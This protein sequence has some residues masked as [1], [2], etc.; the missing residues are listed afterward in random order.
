MA[1]SALRPGSATATIAGAEHNARAQCV[2]ARE[3]PQWVDYGGSGRVPRLPP[4]WW[5]LR[6]LGPP[7]SILKHFWHGCMANRRGARDKQE[8]ARDRIFARDICAIILGGVSLARQRR[9]GEHFAHYRWWPRRDPS[10]VRLVGP[11]RGY[12]DT[13]TRTNGRKK[14]PKIRTAF[15]IRGPRTVP[16]EPKSMARGSRTSPGPSRQKTSQFGY[17]SLD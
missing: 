16:N 5:S 1:I 7:S 4:Q 14:K 9:S 3:R 11:T 17:F 15:L 6:V 10:S 13:A 12:K 8:S 2:R